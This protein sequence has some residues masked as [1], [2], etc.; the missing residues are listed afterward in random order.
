MSD[1][2]NKPDMRHVMRALK[3]FQRRTVDYVFRRMYQDSDFTTRFLIADEVGLGKTLE[4]RGL[5]AKV[6]DH[7]WDKVKRI[8]IVYICSN[9]DIARQN[10]ARLN[11]GEKSDFT[12]PARLTLL[13]RYVR[14]LK[15][16]RRLNFVAFTPGTSFDLKSSCGTG[17]ERAL[18]FHA[19]KKT[20][21]MEGRAPYNVFA[22]DMKCV[23]FVSICDWIN[24]EELESEIIA[25]FLTRLSKLQDEASSE[26]KK[27]LYDT[28][29]ALCAT[30]HRSDAQISDEDRKTRN[31]FIGE[32]RRQM[33]FSCLEWLQPDLIIM[34][35]FQRFK[36]LLNPNSEAGEL[37]QELIDYSDE[38]SATRVLLL[39]AT[40]YKMYSLN[41]EQEDE[42][43]YDDFLDTLK[44][45]QN[46]K[47][48]TE[49][50]D[51][52]LD[53]YSKELHRLRSGGLE[54]LVPIKK[55]MESQML[56][57][58]VR[59]ER[60]AN[61]PD[62]NGMLREVVPSVPIPEI[63]DINHYLGHAKIGHCLGS[64]SMLEYWKSAPYLF[65][66]MEEYEIKRAFQE[67]SE[68]NTDPTLR[69]LLLENPGVLLS[70]AKLK[71]YRAVNPSNA[72]LR[73]LIQDVI[74]SGMWKFLW[75]PPALPYY[76]LFDEFGRTGESTL[77]KRLVFS[78]WHVV[79]KAIAALISYEA[80]R[81]CN[82]LFDSKAI[83]TPK[84]RKKKTPLLRFSLSEGRLTGMPVLGMI[85]PAGCLADQTD[86][87]ALTKEN[88]KKNGSVSVPSF[89]DL[90]E[91]AKKRVKSLL[92]D[93][94]V[95]QK[96]DNVADED[97]YW[98]APLL[99]DLVRE[100]KS[101][102]SWLD[103][104]NIPQIWA[105]EEEGK[106]QDREI[107]WYDHIR[108]IR[109]IRREF[110][111]GTLVMGR[112]PDDL[113][114]VLAWIG[115]SGPGNCC[116]RS[117]RRLGFT[118]YEVK[119]R[120]IAASMAYAFLTLFNLPESMAVIRGT[121]K[122]NAT[123][124]SYWIQVLKYSAAG[125][126]QAV[127]DE[128][129]HILRESLGRIDSSADKTLPDIGKAVSDV[130][131]LRTSRVGYDDIMAKP[132]HHI[133]L[134]SRNMRV[135]Y[136]M[137]FGKQEPEEGGEPTREDQVRAAFN[138]PFWPFVL[139]S[140]SIGQE[141]L[142]FHQYCHAI[143]HWNLP[144]N[145]VHLEQREGRIHRYKGHAVRKNLAQ[146]YRSAMIE[147]TDPWTA[148]FRAARGDCPA[149][150]S[151]ISPFWILEVE[152]GACIERHVP[153]IPTSSEEARFANLKK[154][155]SLYRLAF[156]QLRQADLVDFL[157]TQLDARQAADLSRKILLNLEPPGAENQR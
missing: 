143:V 93:V 112:Q 121:R 131:R 138:S 46:N 123:S 146:K 153:I 19:L 139:A 12:P 74:E 145:P 66:F 34:D 75:M 17:E 132:R 140:T 40:P 7:L 28:F 94:H 5:I 57:V 115:M 48:K 149:G 79:P 3:D 106:E 150:I 62:R 117:L 8:D 127:L 22:V 65:N 95:S 67:S 6:V 154:S 11:I 9:A 43:H 36:H 63:H 55:E 70:H 96:S 128:Y 50:F 20:W 111:A 84:A 99:I 122:G 37:A 1:I 44:F 148:M 81:R 45:L 104:E 29:G 114:E 89:V 91:I 130:L 129:V 24:I 26:G 60:L 113:V 23:N 90:F 102:S 77:T 152:G 137:R 71:R 32:L 110:Q 14:S 13:P 33:A 85:F 2:Q 30:F 86:P 155:L 52:L 42:V 31:A 124:E 103:Q 54:M 107:R 92:A 133:H 136:A 80:E 76:A 25:G 16:G 100:P 58:M 68:T 108:E 64:G 156:G 27:G 4:A 134:F 47:A 87:L 56:R 120:I 141:G 101:T 72:R 35:E 41:G 49:K 18:L 135:R 147:G 109:R 21:K 98:A 118:G 51:H 10:I 151:E 126:L 116:L 97:W 15:D 53:S 69:K 59:T 82:L 88:H 105:G 125:C 61:S 73:G 78:C 142:D 157:G 144:A 39:S 38:H 83:N 119:T